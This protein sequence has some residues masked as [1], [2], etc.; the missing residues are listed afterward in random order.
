MLSAFD[1]YYDLLFAR[2]EEVT[3]IWEFIDLYNEM[4]NVDLDFE[5]DDFKEYKYN[6][7]SVLK[8]FI[9]QNKA[10]ATDESV[11]EMESILEDALEE[12]ASATALE[13]FALYNEYRASLEEAFVIDPENK[14]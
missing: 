1:E 11:A 9:E 2:L 6:K 12:F 4:I 7:I 10:V 13:F 8:Y 5:F 14:P 3:D